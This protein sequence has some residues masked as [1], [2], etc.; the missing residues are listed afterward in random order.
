M[1]IWLSNGRNAMLPLISVVIPNWNGRK[2]L[3]VCID[4][5]M[6]Q[7]HHNLEIIVVDNASA[8]DSIAYLQKNFPDVKVIKHSSNLGFGA[9]NNAGI[10]A[11]R[12]EYL[13]MLNNDTRLEPKCI[14][15]LRNSID[16]DE[17]FGACASKILLEYEDNLLDVAGIAVCLDGLSIGRGR[18]ESGD[19]FID[20]EEVFFASDCACLYKKDMLDDIGLTN[21]VYDE[22]FFAYADETD[23]GWRAQLAGWK[24]IYTPQAVVH[25][26]HSASSSNY[27]PLKAFLV[28]RNRIWVAVKS[29]PVSFLILGLSY[30]ILRY[31]YQAVG[32]LT[33]KGA[34]GKFAKEA[35][36]FEL[37]KILIKANV[38]AFLGLPKM[39]KKRR[40][41]MKKKRIA[42][43]EIY[44]LLK[45]FGI[46]AK[47]IAMKE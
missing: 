11:A 13:M 14:E 20:E 46:G 2:Y 34:A 29:F 40:E 36:K 6:K 10:R 21:E 25:H 47:K 19:K 15:E 33:G 17:N 44:T 1:C 43:R 22:D 7:S 42:N 37:I 4:S 45:R 23:M 5:L 41:I 35:N 24:C 39:L 8:D 30:T 31:F 28:E 26:L 3:E 12:G 32:A 38:S 18:L 16:K 27:S 9:A